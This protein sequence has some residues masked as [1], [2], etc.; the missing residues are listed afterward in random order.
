[1]GRIFGDRL[2]MRAASTCLETTLNVGTR[3][4][5]LAHEQ[6]TSV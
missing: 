6:C 5:D 4:D 2:N 3:F 1:M